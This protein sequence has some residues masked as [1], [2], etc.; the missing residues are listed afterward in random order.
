MDHPSLN[1]LQTAWVDLTIKERSKQGN[2]ARLIVSIVFIA[3][4]SIGYRCMI[5]LCF[6]RPSFDYLL[7]AVV[8]TWA[9]RKEIVSN[10]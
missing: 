9:V 2:V 6:S 4:K 5:H 10:T 8:F 3:V 7:L 1:N